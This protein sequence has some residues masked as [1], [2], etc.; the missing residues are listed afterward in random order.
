MYPR[1]GLFSWSRRRSSSTGWN[2]RS[3]NPRRKVTRRIKLTHTVLCQTTNLVTNNL[4]LWLRK[5]VWISSNKFNLLVQNQ[6]FVLELCHLKTPCRLNILDH[7]RIIFIFSWKLILNLA[8]KKL[9]V[10]LFNFD[11]K[12]SYGS[13]INF[14]FFKT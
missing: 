11:V 9:L 4:K 8:V 2:K 6:I 12:Y 7:L 3:R 5:Y 10:F 13:I 1:G 14:N